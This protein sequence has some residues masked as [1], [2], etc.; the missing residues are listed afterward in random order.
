MK[1]HVGVV[2]VVTAGLA[3]AIALSVVASK[4]AAEPLSG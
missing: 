4:R 2:S 1:Q 3:L